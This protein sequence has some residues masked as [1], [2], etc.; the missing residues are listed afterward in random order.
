MRKTIITA[1]LFVIWCVLMVGV[2][3]P[4]LALRGTVADGLISLFL[5]FVTFGFYAYVAEAV[6]F[7][8]LK[9]PTK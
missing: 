1:I 3:W 2:V 9:P 4:I 5:L 7:A 6:A 8:V